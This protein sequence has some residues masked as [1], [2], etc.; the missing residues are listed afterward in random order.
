MTRPEHVGIELVD[1]VGC[2]FLD[3]RPDSQ[4]IP[5]VLCKRAMT[6]E[7]NHA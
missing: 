5:D 4:F 1:S 6:T 7:G 3:H 2:N